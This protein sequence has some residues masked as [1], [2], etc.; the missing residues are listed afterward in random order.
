VVP[1]LVSVS[2]WSRRDSERN[3][4]FDWRID[5]WWTAGRE[6]WVRN[7]R[8]VLIVRVCRRYAVIMMGF[9]FEATP[10]G[11]RGFWQACEWRNR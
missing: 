11:V 10:T 8:L 1:I 7:E 4:D 5:G 3:F 2:A 9:E 6:D